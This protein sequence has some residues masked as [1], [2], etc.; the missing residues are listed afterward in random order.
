[1]VIDARPRNKTNEDTLRS[2]RRNTLKKLLTEPTLLEMS[3]YPTNQ[4]LLLLG[5][6]GRP[7]T[8]FR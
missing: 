5:P 2:E 3:G 4:D 1:V 6:N 8:R 7:I